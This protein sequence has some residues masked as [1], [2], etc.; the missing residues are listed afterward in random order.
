MTL[1]LTW[2]FEGVVSKFVPL[3]ITGVPPVP[4]MLE[5][6]P[7]VGVNPVM[8]GASKFTLNGEALIAD[9]VG[10]VTEI[11]PVDAPAGTVVTNCVAL[12]EITCALTPLNWIV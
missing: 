4:L 11:G 12:A 9:P 5:A 8:V 6:I 3:I 2:L 7:I 1:N 10:V